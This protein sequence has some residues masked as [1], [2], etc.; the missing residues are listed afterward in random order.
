MNYYLE[1][2]DPFELTN[3]MLVPGVHAKRVPSGDTHI[4]YPGTDGPWLSMRLESMRMGIED[5]ELL[6]QIA[7]VDRKIADELVNSCMTSFTET[8]NDAAAFQ[9][10][11]RRLLEAASI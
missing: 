4:V 1:G 5:Y 11:H 9:Q 6:Q 7:Q 2:Q 8:N 10:V 3:P